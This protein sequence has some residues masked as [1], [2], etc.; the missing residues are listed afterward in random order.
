M[1]SALSHLQV[2]PHQAWVPGAERSSGSGKRVPAGGSDLVRCY[3][4][5]RELP[6]DQP[7]LLG[8]AAAQVS[9]PQPWEAWPR[10]SSPPSLAPEALGWRAQQ[11]GPGQ[12]RERERRFTAWRVQRHKA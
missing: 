6:A 5:Q 10:S 12:E 3:R 9:G 1:T 7:S 11:E 8:L 2:E 4:E